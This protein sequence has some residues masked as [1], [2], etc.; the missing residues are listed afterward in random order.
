MSEPVELPTKEQRNIVSGQRS[1][2]FWSFLLSA[3][4]Y[5]L[6]FLSFFPIIEPIRYALL[7]A[8]LILAL[9]TY[10]CLEALLSENRKILA[11]I[12]LGV[13][14]LPSAVMFFYALAHIRG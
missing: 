3:I 9:S 5:A 6:I 8:L 14:I 4:G 13:S 1:K 2:I 11:S 12:A 10:L 7:T